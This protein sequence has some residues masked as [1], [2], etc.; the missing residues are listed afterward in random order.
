MS[1]IH[2]GSPM[3]RAWRTLKAASGSDLVLYRVGEFYEV[4][5]GDARIV[6]RVLGLQLTRRRQ[7]DNDPLPM[8]GIP[9]SSLDAMA[10]RLLSQGYKLTVSDP[11]S[12]PEGERHI[13]R[14]TP[15]TSVA[16]DVL[17]AGRPNNLLVALAEGASVSFAWMDLSTGE[18][19]TATSSLSGCAAIL[20]RAMPTEILVAQWPED[21]SALAQAVRNTG[22]IV[23]DISLTSETDRL[24]DT[25]LTESLG[26][27]WADTLRGTA[28]GEIEA[29]RVLLAYIAR[30][31]GRF[32]SGISRPRRDLAGDLLDIDDF[33]LRGLNIFNSSAGRDGSLLGV[34]D[35]TVTAAGRRLLMRQLAAPQARKRRIQQRLEMVRHFVDHPTIRHDCQETLSHLEDMVRAS[36]RLS[37]RKG[38]PR[39]LTA[40]RSGLA[41]CA[42]INR[43]MSPPPP[44][45]AGLH[46]EF[47]IVTRGDLATL[48]ATL[49]RAILA[50]PASSPA[51]GDVIAPRFDKRLDA[52]RER[53]AEVSAEIDALR[54]RYSRESGIRSLKI[55][56]NAVIGYHIEVPSTATGKL[57]PGVF[58]LRQ[59]LA[60]S[61]RYTSEE[62]DRL[63]D[64]KD[65]VQHEVLQEEERICRGLIEETLT[66]RKEI[67]RIA[68]AA[69]ILDLVAGLAQ[70]AAEGHWVEPDL[71]ESTTL[72]IIGG[73]HPVAEQ[74]LT[75]EG[76]HFEAND[77]TMREDCR[78]WVI[79]GPNMAGKSTFL[80]QTATIILMAQIGSFVPATR[81]RVGL[82]DRMYSR[83]GAGDDLAAGKSTFMIEMQETATILREAT[84]R[85]FVILDEIGRGTATSDGLAIAQATMEYLHDSVGCRTLLATHYHELAEMAGHFA[86]AVAM[87]MDASEGSDGSS[88]SYR[89][90]P[91]QAGNSYGLH[92]AQMAGVPEAVIRRAEAILV[93]RQRFS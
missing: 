66:L 32:P 40:I 48:L 38:G 64:Q 41:T 83:I 80:R 78:L 11:S 45:L 17:E 55:R 70:A 69:A 84:N 75:A 52:L 67:T 12:E 19:A 65:R 15:G 44:T 9:S 16:L 23:Q 76:G 79:T 49:R 74:L 61:T 36:G 3:V 57:D 92:V 13:H 53:R 91:G 2:E 25:G 6:A 81:A 35:R 90:S 88:F 4:L 27:R 26:E 51:E 1:E 8:C 24:S 22:V 54:D 85:S 5:E 73:R 10:G 62:L 93:E 14:L 29:L 37:L 46:H 33:T 56:S 87:K 50:D 86:G 71:E 43:L 60:S 34:L 77:C 39:D 59:G 20:A 47:E 58:R 31:V 72:E 30:T 28:A 82:V 7:K 68:Q 42:D 63:A 18:A 89:I 21:S